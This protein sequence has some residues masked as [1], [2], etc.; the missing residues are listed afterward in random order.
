L[1]FLVELL[2]ARV[3]FEQGIALYDP[4][5]HRSLAFRYGIDPGV[6]CL[7]FASWALWLL[8]YVDQALNKSHEALALA[9][10]LS[11][12]HSLVA[13]IAFAA[14]LH[15]YCREV[16][17]VR[18]RAEAAIML[19]TEQGFAYWVA[20]GAP[21]CGWALAEQGQGEEGIA[22]IRQGMVALRAAGAEVQR[23]YFLA[24][25]AE[26]YAKTGQPEACPERSRRE[27]LNVLAEALDVVRKTG[28]R[29]YK[30][31]LYRL[32]GE[33]L[34]A[35]E[36]KNQKSKGK[37]QKSNRRRRSVFVRPSRLPA[38]RVRSLWSCG[39]Q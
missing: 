36:G 22:Q 7:S 10:Q 32:K 20:W 37:R 30:A 13:A 8:G 27:G 11:H 4:Q 23:T 25:L 2:P 26:A 3:H 38:S 17:A 15:Q 24:L 6:L 18:E 14:E 33:L 12:P 35:Q 5:Q 9:Q 29:H 31:E 39:R 1:F 21:F 28:E 19:S 34:L 16:Q